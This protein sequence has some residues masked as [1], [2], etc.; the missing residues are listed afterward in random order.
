MIYTL[1][2]FFIILAI[3][4][5]I[6]GNI[7]IIKTGFN[8]MDL[9]SI[10]LVAILFFIFALIVKADYKETL[11]LASAVI[12][13]LI[14]QRANRGISKNGVMVNGGSI[15]F[16]REY[17]F[18]DI[19]YINVENEEEFVSFAI[20]IKGS[21]QVDLQRFKKSKKADIVSIFKNNGVKLVYK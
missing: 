4:N 13:Y 3:V 7:V 12:L 18:S 8:K 1:G 15:L 5:I 14:T 10:I 21:N 16:L 20:A 11:A 19:N 9:V 17:L 6:K 2:I